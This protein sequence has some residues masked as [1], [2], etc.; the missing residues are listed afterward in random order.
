MSQI[1][2]NSVLLR[3][4]IDYN[5]IRN[6]FRITDFRFLGAIKMLPTIDI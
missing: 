4:F 1:A 2:I 6:V 5:L 3:L